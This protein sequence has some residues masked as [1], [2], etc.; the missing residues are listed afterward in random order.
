[1]EKWEILWRGRN[2]WRSKKFVR[3]GGRNKWRSGRLGGGERT[4]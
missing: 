1:M 2:E 4:N 3:V